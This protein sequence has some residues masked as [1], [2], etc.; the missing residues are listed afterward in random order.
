MQE[1]GPRNT[2]RP[3]RPE[4][5]DDGVRRL[6]APNP[7]PMTHW[8][9]N[10]YIIGEGRV[11]II[12]PGPND[13]RHLESILAAT[14]GETITHILVTHAHADHSA[15]ARPLAE[16]TGAALL[17]FGPPEAGRHPIMR[18]LSADGLAG[19]GEGVDRAFVPDR[20]IGESDVL[21][22]E[23]WRL[24]VL[25][26]PGHFAGHLAFRLGDLLFSGDHVMDWASTVISPPDGNLSD[27]MSTS[28]RLCEA[29]LARLH[30]GHGAP[31]DDPADR[32]A[33]LIEHRERR[34]AEI[35]DLL[36]KGSMTPEQIARLIYTDIPHRML[37]AARR[38]VL[39]HLIDLVQRNVVT[40]EPR[41]ALDAMFS[42][43]RAGPR[44]S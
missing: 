9:T 43:A 20:P 5:L 10:T 42:L 22:G 21:T 4:T 8:G 31:I 2:P 18:R 15:L 39:A 32:L 1:K 19:G 11:A 35:L 34:E 28:R 26:T 40:A 14:A 6:L 36:S 29:G 37:P 17:G 13:P 41:L 27:F 23:G 3:G 7:G 12:D 25:H 38:N 16:R 44:N 24:H 30:T 33:W